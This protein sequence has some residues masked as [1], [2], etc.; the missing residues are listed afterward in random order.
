MNKPIHVEVVVPMDDPDD[1]HLRLYFFPPGGTS[2]GRGLG[3]EVSQ[4]M[5]KDQALAAA[6]DIRALLGLND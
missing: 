3:W 4:K 5:S 1:Y 2:D 6:R